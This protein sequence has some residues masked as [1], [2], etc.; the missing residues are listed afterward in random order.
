MIPRP[1]KIEE[2]QKLYDVCKKIKSQYNEDHI[3]YG[4]I[5]EQ[6]DELKNRINS[7]RGK[8]AL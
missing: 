6:M 8:N 1:A 4:K 2:L 3:E 7:M 5:T